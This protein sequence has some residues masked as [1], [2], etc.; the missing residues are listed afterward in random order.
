MLLTDFR[1]VQVPAATAGEDNRT[2]TQLVA[3]VGE[4]TAVVTTKVA[5]VSSTFQVSAQRDTDK[6]I[7]QAAALVTRWEAS[8]APCNDR[9]GT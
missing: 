5:M 9:S 7:E 4:D 6:A 1:F 3:T 2:V 8:A